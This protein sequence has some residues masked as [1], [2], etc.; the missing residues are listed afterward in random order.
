MYPS[1]QISTSTWAVG[2]G[3][4]KLSEKEAMAH[5]SARM[6]TAKV[7]NALALNPKE[8]IFHSLTTEKETKNWIFSLID[9]WMYIFCN[10][11]NKDGE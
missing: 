9:F 2:E 8:C 4:L 3:E 7:S 6:V 11:M 10:H 1:T 5:I